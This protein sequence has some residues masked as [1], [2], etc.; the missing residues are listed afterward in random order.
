MQEGLALLARTLLTPQE[1]IAVESPCYS[2]AWNLFNSFA[3][4]FTPYRS[5][6]AGCVPICCLSSSARWPM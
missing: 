4:I 3:P 2:G 6:T 1:H 5:M